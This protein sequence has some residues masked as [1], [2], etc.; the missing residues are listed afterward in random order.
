MNRIIFDI[1][2][3]VRQS[4]ILLFG[5]PFLIFLLLIFVSVSNITSQEHQ[6]AKAKIMDTA[7]LKLQELL[8]G[9]TEDI[10]SAY[11][12]ISDS[13]DVTDEFK[14]QVGSMVEIMETI[15][16]SV[17]QLTKEESLR[18]DEMYTFLKMKSDYIIE[19]G[20][21]QLRNFILLQ[22]PELELY[23][24][25]SLTTPSINQRNL[26]ILR[27]AKD[28]VRNL[29]SKSMLRIENSVQHVVSSPEFNILPLGK[30][31][32]LLE[33]LNN[34]LANT[35]K[36]YDK[37]IIDKFENEAINLISTYERF[38]VFMS[39]NSKYE[40]VLQDGNVI[41]LREDDISTYLNFTEE[42]QMRSVAMLDAINN[43]MIMAQ[44][45]I[46]Y[47]Y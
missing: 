13:S 40:S 30:R 32:L 41:F 28:E 45:A 47:D 5:V 20:E 36:L 23:S 34:S 17:N 31:Q 19:S 14:G 6:P 2:E 35:R 43:Y 16:D 22:N 27:S 7:P 9:Y 42:I 37:Q 24:N 26:R 11:N 10:Q 4:P 25:I 3:D 29:Y 15:S 33:F 38:Y 8:T 44:E 46:E 1:L 21:N 39:D 18:D 12:N